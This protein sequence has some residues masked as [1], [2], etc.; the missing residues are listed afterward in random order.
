MQGHVEFVDSVPSEHGGLEHV[1]GVLTEHSQEY[2]DAV[3]PEMA[4]SR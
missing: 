1:D 4:K 3:L 2:V